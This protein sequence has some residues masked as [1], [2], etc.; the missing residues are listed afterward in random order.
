MRISEEGRL[1]CIHNHNVEEVL[2]TVSNRMSKPRI[3]AEGKGQRRSWS[4]WKRSYAYDF[5]D[6]I[7][8][9][10]TSSL[11]KMSVSWISSELVV[12]VTEQE[13]VDKKLI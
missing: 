8:L 4:T 11:H 9:L 2:P 13:K 7:S 6:G 1:P 10:K 5:T 3:T 12:W